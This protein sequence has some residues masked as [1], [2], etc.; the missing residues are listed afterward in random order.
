MEKANGKDQKVVYDIR[1]PTNDEKDKDIVFMDVAYE[2][3]IDKKT[4][5]L[6]VDYLDSLERTDAW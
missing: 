1:I 2:E 5:I 3:K 6:E 4:T